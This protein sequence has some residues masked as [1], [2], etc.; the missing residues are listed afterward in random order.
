[1]VGPNEMS[2]LE[3]DINR[4]HIKTDANGLIKGFSFG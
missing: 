3:Y 2:T 4:V 1:M